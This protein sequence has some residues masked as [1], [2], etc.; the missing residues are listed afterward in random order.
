MW[1]TARFDV[2]F[3]SLNVTKTIDIF[4]AH[5]R[6]FKKL[7]IFLMLLVIM[8]AVPPLPKS[9]LIFFY[10]QKKAFDLNLA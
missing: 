6:F 5:F 10:Q 2:L 9:P 1:D 8:H 3:K 7:H 4:L